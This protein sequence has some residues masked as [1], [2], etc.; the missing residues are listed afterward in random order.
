MWGG[1]SRSNHLCK[2]LTGTNTVCTTDLAW[3]W[4]W[5]D[6]LSV[7]FITL[8]STGLTSSQHKQSQ[9]HLD[10]SFTTSSQRRIST[11]FQVRE[12]PLLLRWC[13]VAIDWLN[14]AGVIGNVQSSILDLRSGSGSTISEERNP[15]KQALDRMRDLRFLLEPCADLSPP[16]NSFP[17]GELWEEFHK[18]TSIL[19]RYWYWLRLRF[20]AESLK[21]V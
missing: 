7:I 6:L 14:M 21:L 19:E 15:S 18:N 11:G 12:R 17:A 5:C 10:Y 16:H 2:L 3:C 4:W 1:K 13:Q 8:P 20:A 9:Q